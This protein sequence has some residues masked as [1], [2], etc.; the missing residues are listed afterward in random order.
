[1][2]KTKNQ[3]IG[4]VGKENVSDDS[5]TLEAFSR[6]RS[7]ALPIKPWF[8]ARPQN[9]DEVQKLVAWA[10]ETNTPLVPVSSG[11]PHFYGDTVP[12]APGGIIVD[13][14]RMN[15]ILHIDRRNR[16]VVVEP[17]VTYSQLEPELAK[18]G[19]RVTM[20]LLPRA[21]KSV[22]TSLL[23]RQPTLIP[24]YNYS[25]PEPLR[26]CGVVWGGGEISFTGH[27]GNGSYSLEE[28]WKAGHIPIDPRG[29]NATDFMRLLT[30]AQ[31][32]MG[33][34]VWASIKCEILPGIR[35]LFFI[36]ADKLDNLV[37]FSCRLQRLRLG[38][39][40]LIVNNTCLAC[41]LGKSTQQISLLKKDLPSWV[42][43]IG[44]A[45]RALLPA[46]KLDVQEKDLNDLVQQFGLKL[47][48]G[49]PGTT[50]KEVLDTILNTSTEPYWKFKYKGGCDDIF[51][52]TTLDKAPQY[53]DTMNATAKAFR[54]PESKIGVYIQP[55]HQGVSHHC[56]FNLYYDPKDAKES[57]KLKALYARASEELIGQGAYF[58][59]PYGM[60]ANLVYNRDA[61]STMALRKVKRIFDPNNIMNPGKL[62]F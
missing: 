33:I 55:Q 48:S 30:G 5:K 47:L 41:M 13:L 37:D 29:P 44:L 24:R 56:E 43:I 45:G 40:V 25:L 4:I 58:A 39:E 17:G 46:E 59:R 3:L 54:Y 50:N 62:C 16:V 60:W 52:L 36:P 53:I 34:V 35:K 1:V 19:M 22:I 7:I 18:E 20:P 38:D 14:S 21:N 12:S 10:N 32:S 31:G 42:M 61:Q 57:A 6:D 2:E 15:K 51:F 8:V 27:A 26:N 28:Q 11:A 49:L 9:T 23:E